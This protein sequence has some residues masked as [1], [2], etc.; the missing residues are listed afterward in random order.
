MTGY[1]TDCGPQDPCCKCEVRER[2]HNTRGMCDDCYEE[3]DA[4]YA[5]AHEDDRTEEGRCP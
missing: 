2:G 4:E 3:W 5:A 1:P